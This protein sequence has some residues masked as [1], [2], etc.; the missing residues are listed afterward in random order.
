MSASPYVRTQVLTS[1][2]P[3]LVVLMLQRAAADLDAGA[4]AYRRGQPADAHRPLRRA[5]DLLDHL[6]AVL[7]VT[8]WEHAGRLRGLYRFWTSQIPEAAARGDH[9]TLARIRDQVDGLREA[10]E[11][12]AQTV[13]DSGGGR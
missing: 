13:R 5:M 2:S 6:D 3:G 10:F 12:A 7:D 1:D 8:A 4:D 9:E 11:A